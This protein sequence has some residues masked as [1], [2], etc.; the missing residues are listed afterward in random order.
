[1][2]VKYFIIYIFIKDMDVNYVFYIQE[3]DDLLFIIVVFVK[4]Y[5]IFGKIKDFEDLDREEGNGRINYE[6]DKM[7]YEEECRVFKEV[8]CFLLVMVIFFYKNKLKVQFNN[9]FLG[10]KFVCIG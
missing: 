1:M 9:C 5:K 6:E 8:K 10:N 2:E 3:G 7:R 4:L